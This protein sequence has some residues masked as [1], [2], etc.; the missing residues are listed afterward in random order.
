MWYNDRRA[1]AQL[2]ASV[3]QQDWSWDS[4]AL[5]YMELYHRSIK[6]GRDKKKK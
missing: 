3:M 6:E 1:W 4:P 2:A 5:D